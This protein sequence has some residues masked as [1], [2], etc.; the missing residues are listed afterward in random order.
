M[1]DWLNELDHA[2]AEIAAPAKSD[3]TVS[4]M[5]RIAKWK[6]HPADDLLDWY[7]DDLQHLAGVTDTDLQTIVLDYLDNLTLY[8]GA[9]VETPF[10]PHCVTCNDCLH[11]TRGNHPHLGS[12]AA[13]VKGALLGLWDAHLRGC[14]KYQEA[15]A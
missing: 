7:K 5:K 9:Q 12:C 14:D 1:T 3:N 4:R 13:G 2:P 15:A 11:F 10:K 8:R 6:G